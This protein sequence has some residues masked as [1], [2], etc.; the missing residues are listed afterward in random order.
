MSASEIRAALRDLAIRVARRARFTADERRK[1]GRQ[2]LKDAEK[3]ES[4]V[5]LRSA[6]QSAWAAG[7]D[8]SSAA[9]ALDEARLAERRGSEDDNGKR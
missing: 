1:R 2:R 8:F 7:N 4:E 9:D 6:A 3:R 5:L